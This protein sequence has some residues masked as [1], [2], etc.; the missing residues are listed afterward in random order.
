MAYGINIDFHITSSLYWINI[1]DLSEWGNIDELPSIIE[2][3]IPGTE[4]PLTNYYQK[5][6]V[7][8]FNS[9]TMLLNC[10]PSCDPAEKVPLM[11]GLYHIKV[12]GSPSLY[13]KERYFLKDDMFQLDLD[14]LYLEYCNNL[15]SHSIDNLTEIEFIRN[16]AHSAVRLGLFKKAMTLFSKA[17]KKLEKVKTCIT[18]K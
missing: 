6:K 8:A 11:D 2:I 14:K 7:N 1:Y 10:E 18:C 5:Y 12:I 15:S 16:S 4:E 3:T 9:N 17:Q 13:N